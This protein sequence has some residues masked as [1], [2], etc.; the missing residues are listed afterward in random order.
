MRPNRAMSKPVQIRTVSIMLAETHDG[1][2]QEVQPVD[3]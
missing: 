1:I 3:G 2:T